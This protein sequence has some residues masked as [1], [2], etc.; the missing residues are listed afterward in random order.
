MD[1]H[2]PHR[3]TRL[4]RVSSKNK[5]QALSAPYSRPP[6]FKFAYANHGGDIGE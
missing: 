1:Y 5:E 6:L 3:H 4:V 2:P